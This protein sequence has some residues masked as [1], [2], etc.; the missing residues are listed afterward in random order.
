VLR[1]SI[2]NVIIS[3]CSYRAAI[4]SIKQAQSSA[5]LLS[6]TFTMR[7]P[8]NGSQARKIFDLPQRLYS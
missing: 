3:A 4:S 7:F 5:V 1:L 8:A 6:V 2:T